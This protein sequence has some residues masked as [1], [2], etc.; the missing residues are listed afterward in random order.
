[1]Q[2]TWTT[3]RV[4]WFGNIRL[5]ILSGILVALALIPESLAF[6]VIA[7]VDPSVTL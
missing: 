2:R 7:G 5:D 4:E 3:V 1:M 6:A